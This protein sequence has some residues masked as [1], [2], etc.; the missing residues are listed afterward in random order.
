M[1]ETPPPRGESGPPA[2]GGAMGAEGD[3]GG[4]GGSAASC[5]ALDGVSVRRGAR[6]KRV[7]HVRRRRV[8]RARLA[9]AARNLRA[10]GKVDAGHVD[11]RAAL[12]DA[13]ARL[14]RVRLR[15]IQKVKR[16]RRA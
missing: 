15:P 9:E 10:V 11:A 6:D 5:A 7:A 16:P 14:E 8:A 4:D 13:G 12:K 1:S 3:G 2:P